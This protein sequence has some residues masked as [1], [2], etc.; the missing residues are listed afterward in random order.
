VR[1]VDFLRSYGPKLILAL[2]T[3]MMNKLA[4]SFRIFF[5]EVTI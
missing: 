5:F 3:G 4:S 1:D 2:V